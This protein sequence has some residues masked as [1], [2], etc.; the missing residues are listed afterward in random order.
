MRT[1]IDSKQTEFRQCQTITLEEFM[2]WR[3]RVLGISVE[4][5][6]NSNLEVRKAWLW[7]FG[8]QVV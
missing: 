4:L 7:V 5:H 3:D 8:V 2:E 6:K 1:A